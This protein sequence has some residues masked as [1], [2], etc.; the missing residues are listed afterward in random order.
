MASRWVHAFKVDS[1]YN[2]ERVLTGRVIRDSFGSCDIEAVD[3]SRTLASWPSNR[4]DPVSPDEARSLA[5]Q[6]KARL[7]AE[8]ERKANR[9]IDV[10]GR[11]HFARIRR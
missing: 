10:S 8:D 4:I 5:A 3:G 11:T 6:R 2:R 7:V 9:G 1:Q